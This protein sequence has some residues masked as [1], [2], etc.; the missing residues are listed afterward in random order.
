MNDTFTIAQDLREAKAMAEGLD[1][2]LKQD[3][4]YGAVGGGGFFSFNP[5][6]ALTIGALLMRL[7]RLHLLSDQ[8]S[9]EQ[10]QEL[11][12]AQKTHDAVSDEWRSHYDTRLNRE[13]LSRIKAIK[14]YLDEAASDPKLAARSYK[15]ETLRRTIVEE[16][17][18]AMAERGMEHDDLSKQARGMDQRLRR[19]LEPA[20]FQ[21]DH[22]LEA[23]Y[24]RERFWWLYM[25]PYQPE[26][27]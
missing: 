3:S 8:L 1:G 13:A 16:C 14:P 10:R 26:K 4:L 22:A 6:P 18:I 5:M 24:P 19:Y 20:D 27:A 17:L 7:R 15:P 25:Q 23:V 9:A 2:Y 21:W 12:A 11:D